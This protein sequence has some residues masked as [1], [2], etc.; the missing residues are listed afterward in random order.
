[1]HFVII[2]NGVAGIE[3]ATAVRERHP[4]DRIT[5]VSE[6]SDHFFSR[7]A[8]MWVHAGQ[9]SH[10]E[11]E[12]HERDLYERL[13]LERVRARAVGLDVAGRKVRLGGDLQSL[14]YDR[15]LIACGSRA[16]PGPW[17]GSDLLGVGH[18]VTHQDLDWLEREVHGEANRQGPPRP[19]AHLASSTADSPYRRRETARDRRGRAPLH[20]AVIGG[21]LIG[22]EAV[23]IMV[24]AG[25]LPRFIMR[26]DWFWPMAINQRESRFVT[27]RMAAHGVEVLAQENVAALHG[28]DDGH[29]TAIETDRARYPA[30][31]AVIAIGVV[32]NTNWLQDAGVDLTP[33][34]AIVVDE[35]LRTSVAGISAAGDCAAV[36]MGGGRHAPE[37]LWYTG[38]S[39][40]RIAG[41]NLA[42]SADSGVC[43][44]YDR[45]V[46]FNSAKLFDLEYTTVGTL[47][48]GAAGDRDFFFEERS[49]I[50][51][52]T[53][54]AVDRDGVKG[55]NLLG[56]RWDHSRL[57]D[58]LEEGRPLEYVLDHLHEAA[59]DTE[60]CPPLRIDAESRRRASAGSSTPQPRQ[61]DS[62][63]A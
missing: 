40:G 28:D 1:M 62:T 13:Q 19:W 51:S 12:P 49:P 37:Q 57:I 30:D 16:R 44:P 23:E 21:G 5:V 47:D 50:R 2:G 6:E 63:S 10:A 41:A 27:D 55:F 60:F 32:P 29:L 42:A 61:D 15:L 18:F 54:I 45:G 53:R 31:L 11:I 14:C 22:I 56:R 25:L 36:S 38:R 26:D 46:P 4:A 35:N 39:Q 7:T 20:P 43:R 58:F 3:A 9:L 17:P 52:T 33:G 59:F 8:L 48:S 24:T 34:G